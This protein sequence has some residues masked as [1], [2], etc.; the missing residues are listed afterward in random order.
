MKFPQPVCLCLLPYDTTRSLQLVVML[1]ANSRVT[2]GID[3]LVPGA[4]GWQQ[5]VAEPKLPSSNDTGHKGLM[6]GVSGVHARP[7]H[8]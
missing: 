4:Q 8:V 7:A 3:N 6:P 1:D 2:A 5:L